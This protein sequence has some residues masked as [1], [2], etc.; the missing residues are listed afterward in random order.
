MKKN[1]KRK[2]G[3][4]IKE[5]L[6]PQKLFKRKRFSWDNNFNLFVAFERPIK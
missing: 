6:L 4:K 5:I 2:D 1:E 3:K